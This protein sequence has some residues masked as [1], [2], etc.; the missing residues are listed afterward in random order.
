MHLPLDWIRNWMRQLPASQALATCVV[1][2]ML[3]V[4]LT[5]LRFWLIHIKLV[6]VL[7]TPR[8]GAFLVWN[9]FLAWLPLV[10]ALI[11]WRLDQLKRHRKLEF[12]AAALSWLLFYPNAPYLITDLVHLRWTHWPQYWFD[13]I[14][15]IQTA[16]TGLIV[17][18][19]SL[20]LM[21]TIVE[22][23]AGWLM[24]WTFIAITAILGGVGVFLGRFKRFNSWDAIFRPGQ[25]YESFQ[26]WP[27]ESL[28]TPLS[29][30]FPVL[31]ALFLFTSYV[32]LHSLTKTS[33]PGEK[34][35]NP[36]TPLPR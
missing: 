9:L 33:L 5:A 15:I 16:F 3:C 12:A 11:A 10:F 24:S 2:S 23:H 13:L 28:N 26:S 32:L 22:R 20:H 25:L 18:F 19:L 17:G 30:A 8:H 34:S 4:M 6:H 21:R 31:F 36:S 29:Y 1:V 27:D 14:V 7:Y 35:E